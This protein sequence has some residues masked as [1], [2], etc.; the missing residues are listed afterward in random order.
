[1]HQTTQLQ[2]SSLATTKKSSSYRARTISK[3]KYDQLVK[4][5]IDPPKLSRENEKGLAKSREP[6]PLDSKLRKSVEAIREDPLNE[7]M[8]S[9]QSF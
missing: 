9:S 6:L 4:E 7:R 1:M 5:F 2:Q 8:L 3:M